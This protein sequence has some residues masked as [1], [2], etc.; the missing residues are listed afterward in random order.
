MPPLCQSRLS[1]SREQWLFWLCNPQSMPANSSPPHA[2]HILGENIDKCIEFQFYLK[3]P[4]VFAFDYPFWTSLR[5]RRDSVSPVFSLGQCTKYSTPVIVFVQPLNLFLSISL[6][7]LM[8]WIAEVMIV[9]FDSL[10]AKIQIHSINNLHVYFIKFR[11]N[12]INR[13]GVNTT[14]KNPPS[15]VALTTSLH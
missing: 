11:T 13:I 2:P 5:T 8:W 9:D 6:C 7:I 10:F 12:D 15:I 4:L 14:C 3:L 1:N